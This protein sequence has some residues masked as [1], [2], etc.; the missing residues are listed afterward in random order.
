MSADI[1]KG[2]VFITTGN[3]K[4]SFVGTS[5]PGKNLLAN[6]VIAFDMVDICYCV[7]NVNQNKKR[8]MVPRCAT[9]T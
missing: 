8:N 3:P 1:K 4:P 2:V 6:S 9:L 5:R 7:C